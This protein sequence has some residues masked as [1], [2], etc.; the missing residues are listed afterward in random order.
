MNSLVLALP[1]SHCPAPKVETSPGPTSIMLIGPRKGS[2]R[3]LLKQTRLLLRSL[4]CTRSMQTMKKKTWWKSWR[5]TCS[6]NLNSASSYSSTLTCRYP[7]LLSLTTPEDEEKLLEPYNL[8]AVC[9]LGVLRWWLTTWRI[10]LKGIRAERVSQ[11][12]RRWYAW[13]DRYLWCWLHN[14]WSS[15]W[16]CICQPEWISFSL[17]LFCLSIHITMRRSQTLVFI[18]ASLSQHST[19]RSD[20]NSSGCVTY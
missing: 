6:G 9:P 5:I 17:N 8:F 2:C 4:I 14:R 3:T 10:R 12:W 7:Y 20:E 19:K 18:I 1:T 11:L 16:T 13:G 15:Q